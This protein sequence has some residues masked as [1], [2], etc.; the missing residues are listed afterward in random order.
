MDNS[1]FIDDFPINISILGDWFPSSITERYHRRTV[2]DTVKSIEVYAPVISRS[3]HSQ[4]TSP[5][6]PGSKHNFFFDPVAETCHILSP[7]LGQDW[8][9]NWERLVSSKILT[10]FCVNL[11]GF[12]WPNPSPS[13]HRKPGYV[14]R[15]SRVLLQIGHD[16]S[17]TEIQKQSGL[18]PL[19]LVGCWWVQATKVPG[20]GPIIVMPWIEMEHD[21][22]QTGYPIS[23][24][25]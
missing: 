4:V 20:W 22:T 10:E 6:D 16:L 3:L 17:F 11:I 14:K 5:T 25:W 9:K 12:L 18:K 24:P 19:L 13:S 15:K 2:W 23:K 8:T 21:G 1:L 7:G